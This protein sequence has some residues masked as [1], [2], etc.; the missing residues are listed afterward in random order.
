MN[1]SLPM[2]E[3]KNR[4]ITLRAFA[5]RKLSGFLLRI[6]A[7]DETVTNR[8]TGPT[9]LSELSS[10]VCSICQNVTCIHPTR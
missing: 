1:E 6:Q 3:A 4:L 5:E 2:V 8:S 9:K 7:Y 10:H